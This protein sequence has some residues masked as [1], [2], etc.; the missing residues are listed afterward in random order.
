MSPL[1]VSLLNVLIVLA[2]ILA[3]L[4]MGHRNNAY[5][6]AAGAILIGLAV[7]GYEAYDLIQ[8]GRCEPGQTLLAYLVG[9]SDCV[10]I[11][12]RNLA[13]AQIAILGGALV[14]AFKPLLRYLLQQAQQ[15]GDKD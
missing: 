15:D 9:V 14:L 8:E 11:Q 6:L 4:W 10:G 5:P 3:A 7:Y 2:S 12:G 1:L 13:Y